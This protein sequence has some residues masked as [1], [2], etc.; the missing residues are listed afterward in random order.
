MYRFLR[1][2]AIVR[3]FDVYR[4]ATVHM[5]TAERL[6][7]RR[8]IFVAKT[9]AQVHEHA[10]A[11][12]AQM[13]SIVDDDIIAGTPTQVTEQILFQL[14]RTGAANIVG[15]F[16]GHRCDPGAVRTSC[17]LFGEYVIPALQSASI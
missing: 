11:A 16:A 10:R 17:D 15:F 5:H 6:A 14:G 7:I 3:L 1:T 2:D 13:P 8:C 9:E 12:Q 4:E